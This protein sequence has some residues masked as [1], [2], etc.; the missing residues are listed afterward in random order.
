MYLHQKYMQMM[1]MAE[2][3]IIFFSFF[4][5]LS[6]SHT[7]SLTLSHS[8]SFYC[9]Y[10][11]RNFLSTVTTFLKSITDQFIDLLSWILEGGKRH[12]HNSTCYT[13][14]FLANGLTSRYLMKYSAHLYSRLLLS[15]SWA[16]NNYKYHNV[17][18]HLQY[19]QHN[20]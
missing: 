4:L 13:S 14:F 19:V 2:I 17:W 3:V 8:L 7:H 15:S 18:Q 9:Q 16:C 5:I 20:K 6:L 1:D 10:W 11:K 12:S